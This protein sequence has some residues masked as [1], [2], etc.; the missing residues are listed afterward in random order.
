[1][2]R[3]AWASGAGALAAVLLLGACSERAD[4]NPVAPGRPGTGNPAVLIEPVVPQPPVGGSTGPRGTIAPHEASG[5]RDMPAGTTGS[6][7]GLA[8][9]QSTPV[10]PGV[11]L[12]G[13]LD[14]RGAILQN[15]SPRIAGPTSAPGGELAVEGRNPVPRTP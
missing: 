10:Q 8:D 2:T 1:M 12:D 14:D 9:T 5:G 7:I 4:I 13:G 15:P 11:G 3:Q 6:G